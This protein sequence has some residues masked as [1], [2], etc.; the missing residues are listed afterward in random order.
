MYNYVAYS[1][2]EDGALTKT[3]DVPEYLALENCDFFNDDYYYVLGDT[4][5][6]Y[7][8]SFNA[9]ATWSFPDYATEFESNAFVL[10]NGDI[11][12]QY[13]YVADEDAKKYDVSVVDD[14][15][16]LKLNL[17]SYIVSADNGKAKKV[18]LDYFVQDVVTNYELYDKDAEKTENRFTDNF[19]NI[20]EIVPIVDKK[21]DFS[22]ANVDI[23]L[24]NNKGKAKGS[25]KLLDGK[26]TDLPIKIGDD[27][28]QVRTLTGGAIVK[29]NGKLVKAYNNQMRRVGACFIGEVAL[30]DLELNPIYNLVENDAEVIGSVGDTVYVRAETETGYTVLSFRDGASTTLYTYNESDTAPAL[31]FS[32]VEGVGY[33]TVD[34]A[35]GDHKYYNAN[36]ELLATTTYDLVKVSSSEEYGIIVMISASAETVTY[37]VF[38]V[39]E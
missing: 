21:I 26:A 19:D 37:H 13:L 5:I 35:S 20:A 24:M 22:E 34:T 29:G 9:V 11:L 32:T 39:G 8:R 17:E 1:V 3:C 30:Y 14:G 36:G 2:G 27:L 15:E 6:V 12:V 4:V 33:K 25:L 38:T 28:Y 31:S 7:D 23:V 18:K 16:T 10:N